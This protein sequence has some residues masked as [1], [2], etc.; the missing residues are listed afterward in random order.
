MGL[1]PFGI[2]AIV[3]AV[4]KLKRVCPKCRKAQVVPWAKRRERVRCKSCGAEIA[5]P[6]STP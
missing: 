6:P 4:L 2:G 5:P 1:N 3:S